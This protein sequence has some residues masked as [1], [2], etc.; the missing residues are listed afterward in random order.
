MNN[1]LALF[2]EKKLEKLGKMIN[3]ISVSKML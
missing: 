3:G 1:K 2:E